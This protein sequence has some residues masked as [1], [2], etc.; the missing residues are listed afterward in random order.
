MYNVS[1]SPLPG[2]II[3]I[4]RICIHLSSGGSGIY[5]FDLVQIDPESHSHKQYMFNL[6]INKP[7]LIMIVQIYPEK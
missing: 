2:C 7:K 3:S 1:L 4:V 6:Q 5:T